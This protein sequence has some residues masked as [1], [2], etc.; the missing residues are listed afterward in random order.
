MPRGSVPVGRSLSLSQPSPRLATCPRS[1]ASSRVRA[2]GMRPPPRRSD[3]DYDVRHPPAS[4]H[5]RAHRCLHTRPH[6][7]T[8]AR[9]HAR[10]PARSR[11]R[12]RAR[13]RARTRPRRHACRGVPVMIQRGHT[14]RCGRGGGRG[15]ALPDTVLRQALL[16]L[17]HM[18][19]CLPRRWPSLPGGERRRA[20]EP[21]SSNFWLWSAGPATSQAMVA[22]LGTRHKCGPRGARQQTTCAL[23]SPHHR[24]GSSSG[25]R[26]R[27]W[28][29][30]QP[31]LSEM[32]AKVPRRRPSPGRGLGSTRRRAPL[33][34]T[35]ECACACACATS[36]LISCVLASMYS[37]F[38]RAWRALAHAPAPDTAECRA[39][40]SEGGPLSLQTLARIT[41]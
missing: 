2:G 19:R 36:A 24:E 33:W 4:M 12:S 15:E 37:C 32:A 26:L 11:A 21:R 18:R 35:L 6:A 22:R 30:T 14:R 5:A 27:G 39:P 13:T 20:G 16:P 28:R 31:A 34:T 41:G 40:R 1:P 29:W 3:R 17:Y 7:R 8:P 25:L 23:L 38:V 10:T 9:P